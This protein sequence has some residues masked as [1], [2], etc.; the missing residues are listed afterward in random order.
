MSE[1]NHG[2]DRTVVRA[3]SGTRDA[4]Q[5]FALPQDSD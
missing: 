3:A 1:S 4:A 5:P 2:L